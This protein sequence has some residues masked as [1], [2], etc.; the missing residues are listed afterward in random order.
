VGGMMGGFD[1]VIGNPPYVKHELIKSIKLFLQKYEVY[2]SRA[3]LYVYFYEKGYELLK[4]RGILVYITSNKWIRSLYGKNLRKFLKENTRILKLIDLSGYRVFKAAVD[5]NILICRKEKPSKGYTLKFLIVPGKVK[6]LDLGNYLNSGYL[7]HMVS[8]KLSDN[9]WTL[10]DEKVLS[11]KE[12]IEKVGKPLKEWDVKIY[13][14]ITTGYDKA[15]IIDTET[16]NRILANCRDEEERKRTEEIIKPVLKGR[17]IER[18]RYKWARLWVIGIF[19]RWTR[20][21]CDIED[22]EAWFKSNY[23]SLYQHLIM[24]A[25][26]GN[27]RG[28]SIID[29][30]S[31]GEFWWELEDG[32]NIIAEFEKEKIVWQP[33]SGRYKFAYVPAGIYLSASLFMITGKLY[34][35]KYMLGILNSKFADYLL[36][37]FTNLTS[38]GRYAYG[39]KDKI[40]QLPIPPITKEN[41]SL[42]DQI[43]QRVDEILTL[44][45]SP[46]LEISQEK[47]QKVEK[48][49]VDIDVLVYEL[50]GL[51]DDEIKV[52]EGDSGKGVE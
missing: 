42:V 48:I 36:L 22:Y 39:A 17:D 51:T 44:T 16:R 23:N 32:Y 9:G 15:F 50:Y 21:N 10:G 47:Q 33:I 45:Q 5:T 19:S 8:E 4:E 29:R 35:L 46:D 27:R 26:V 7:Q 38:L 30:L 1:I 11:L 14:G 24:Y 52:I 34:I 41:Q 2:T 18:Y 6:D 13:R 31:Q 20:K 40:E 49:M 25:T 43:V 28:R 12:K 37:L 3:D